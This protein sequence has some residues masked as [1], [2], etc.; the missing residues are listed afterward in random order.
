MIPHI[1]HY[2]WFGR[3]PKSALIREC[4]ASWQEKLPGYTFMEWTEDN[5]DVNATLFTRQAYAAKRYAYVSDYARLC[6]LQQ[7]GG[8]YLDTDEKLLKDITPLLQDASLTAGFETEESVMVGVLAAEPGH[9]LIEQFKTYYEEN[10][11][12]DDQGNIT[13]RPNPRILTGLLTDRGLMLNGRR[14]TLE[15]GITIWPVET[16]CAK[17]RDLQYCITPDTYGVQYY[18]GSWMPR[19]DKIK[20]AVRNGVART[21]GPGTYRRM[22]KIYETLTGKKEKSE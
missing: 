13:A 1:V 9:P 6:A 12:Q 15:G 2:C 11:F 5:F 3:G 18:E 14:Q 8:I 20:W 17:T 19:K 4:M 21:L 7:Y 22:M 10:A 16:F